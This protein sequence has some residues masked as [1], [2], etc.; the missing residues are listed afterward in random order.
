MYTPGKGAG[1]VIAG[2]TSIGLPAVLP[3]TGMNLAVEIAL[4]AAAT[5]VVWAV[6]YGIVA[7]VK[8]RA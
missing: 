3:S 4:V 1:A 6:I 5:L 8:A 7:K 2:V